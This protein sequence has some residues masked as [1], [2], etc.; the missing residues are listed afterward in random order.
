MIHNY[1]RVDRITAVFTGMRPFLDAIEKYQNG[2]NQALAR[3][4]GLRAFKDQLAASLQSPEPSVRAFAAILLGVCGDRA[5]AGQIAKLLKPPALVALDREPIDRGR[6]ATA[7]GMLGAT[8]Y[9]PRLAEYLN[10]A[11]VYDRV[12]AIFGFGYM[13]AKDQSLAIG[14]LLYDKDEAVRTAAE[15]ALGWIEEPQSAQ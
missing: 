4:G 14:R 3:V 10:S 8:E 5:Y 13:K 15:E 9:E 1:R 11:N 2:D 7:L 12:G 6:A